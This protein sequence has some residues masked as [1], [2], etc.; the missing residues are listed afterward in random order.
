M[1][2]VVAGY[3]KFGQLALERLT[4]AFRNTSVLVVEQSSDRL[5]RTPPSQVSFFRGDAVSFLLESPVLHDEDVIIPTVPFHLTAA[6]L[7]SAI[8]DSR[9][10]VFPTRLVELV[11]N[12][13]T[14][15][16][17]NLFASHAHF[18]C[19]DDCPGEA[20]CTV[21]GEVR[22]PL[23]S[24]MK[25]IE[26]PDFTTVVLESKQVLP[27]VGGYALRE[28]KKMV[29]AVRQGK[30]I[31]ATACQCHGVITALEI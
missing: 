27:G 21:T 18:V 8:P 9:A 25:G 6:Y 24:I 20:R 17:W 4:S 28:L 30:N 22:E 19:P 12:P 7:L 11:P 2:F 14:L 5:P 15:D 23:F 26:V 29:K 16:Q 31:I 1:S 3:G 10:L 13:F